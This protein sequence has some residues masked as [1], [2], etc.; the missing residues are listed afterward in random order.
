M[1]GAPS[2]DVYPGVSRAYTIGLI[3]RAPCRR[4]AFYAGETEEKTFSEGLVHDAS[5]AK[6]LRPWVPSRTGQII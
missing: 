6:G 3:V 5:R 2:F 1:I 4:A